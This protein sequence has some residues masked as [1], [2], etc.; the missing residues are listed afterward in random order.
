MLRYVDRE[1]TQQ[2]WGIG[3]SYAEVTAMNTQALKSENVRYS[4]TGGVSH[5]NRSFGFRPAFLDSETHCVYLARFANGEPAPFH[6]L[7]GLPDDVVESRNECG[8][9]LAV[10]RTLVS[11]FVLDECFYSREEA[12][13]RLRGCE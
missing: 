10:K 1:D 9:V 7:D 11:G 6:I 2:A 12:A 8:S 5:G 4:G 3:K 13:R